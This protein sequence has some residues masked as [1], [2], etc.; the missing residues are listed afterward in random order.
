MMKMIEVLAREGQFET[1]RAT[2]EQFELQ[3]IAAYRHTEGEL[4]RV[5]MLVEDVKLQSVTDT[6]LRALGSD[7]ETRIIVEPVDS[8]LDPS[9]DPAAK[10]PAK[11]T[12]R[13]KLFAE[14]RA[15]AT[16]DVNYVL[17]VVLST[18]VAAIGLIE[19]NVAVIVG[20]MVI[21]PLLGPN[22]AL[23]LGTVLGDRRLISEALV[24]GVAGLGIA[25]AISVAIGAV[26]PAD[27]ASREVLARTHLA[28]DGM[29]L[30]LAAGAAGVLSLT[31]GLPAVLVG[32][33]V[34]VALLPPTVV[35]G[36][37]LGQGQ[38]NFAVGSAIFLVGN[39]VCLNLAANVVFWVQGLR[40]RRWIEQRRARQSRALSVAF[41]C[42]SLI[43]LIVVIALRGGQLVPG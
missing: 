20:A 16:L 14:V 27:V 21:A 7:S 42:V 9:A 41:W 11:R 5:R 10:A 2:A 40:P 1:V 29:T 25:L 22:L 33:M 31:T 19:D 38:M 26:W 4:C 24:S 34:A 30:A 39:I 32:V 12:T 3:E 13:E 43:S 37:T 6:L 36:M 35:L 23:S 8:V 15:G 17:L 18:L 28:L